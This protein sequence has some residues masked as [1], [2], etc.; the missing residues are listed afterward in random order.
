MVG[1]SFKAHPASHLLRSQQAFSLVEA[2]IFVGIM[3]IMMLVMVATQ[4]N[5]LKSNNY[6]EFQLKRTQ[7]QTVLIGQVLNDPNNCAC[8]FSG[9]NTFAANPALPGATLTGVTPTQLGRYQFITAGDCATATMP[10]PLIDGTGIDGMKATS[11]QLTNIMNISGTYSGDLIAGLQSTKEVLGPRDLQ[12]RIPVAIEVTPAGAGMVQFRSC[13]MQAVP[14]ASPPPQVFSC[15]APRNGSC[16]ATS[17]P[18]MKFCALTDVNNAGC[19]QCAR[20]RCRVSGPD[21][22]GTFTLSGSRGND[23][24]SDCAMACY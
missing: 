8:W 7:L 2:L 15:T 1:T 20:F 24:A 22:S 5:Q 4:S 16:S 12:L 6:L 18:G 19:N 17:L 10:Q 21:A 9:A 13:S 23:P 3:G 14:P 11:I